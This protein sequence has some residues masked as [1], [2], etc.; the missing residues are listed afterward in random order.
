MKAGEIRMIKYGVIPQLPYYA[1]VVGNP[2]GGAENLV[3][4]QIVREPIID[5]KSEYHIECAKKDDK[6]VLGRPFVWKTF[7][8]EPDEI[9]YFAPDE[10]HD[11]IKL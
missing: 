7:L 3:V 8:K 10:K 4:L 11:Y 5:G 2:V 9:Q 6:G 1:V